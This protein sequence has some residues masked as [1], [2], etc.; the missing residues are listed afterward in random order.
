MYQDQ[1]LTFFYK[2]SN[3]V[4]Y[5]IVINAFTAAYF[6]HYHVVLLQ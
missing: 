6:N 1:S 2:L 3:V 4:T 5:G